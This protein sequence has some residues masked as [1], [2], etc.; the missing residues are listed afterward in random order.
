ME[1]AL[2]HLNELLVQQPWSPNM[3]YWSSPGLIKSY[4]AE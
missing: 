2:E 3:Q 1:L 4:V